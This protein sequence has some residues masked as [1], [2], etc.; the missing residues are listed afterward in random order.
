MTKGLD[1][2]NRCTIKKKTLLI[3]FSF[4]N[5]LAVSV[6]LAAQSDPPPRCDGHGS[7][8]SISLTTWSNGLGS[9]T[10]G[11]HD[12]ANPGT[13]GTPDWAVVGNLPDSRPGTAAFVANLDIGDCGPDDSVHLLLLFVASIDFS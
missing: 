8:Q 1:M 3:G 7:L 5:L 13:F 10:A 9:W 2:L 11:T 12:I 6:D 4:F